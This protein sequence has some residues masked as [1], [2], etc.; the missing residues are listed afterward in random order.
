MKHVFTMKQN[1][2]T[3]SEDLH[4]KEDRTT[5]GLFWLVPDDWET[6]RNSRKE[7]KLRVNSG[8]FNTDITGKQNA[9]ACESANSSSCVEYQTE[10]DKIKL[11]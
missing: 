6:H 4:P 9:K 2:N 5:N 11:E 10:V 3:I 1:E 7:C 8:Q